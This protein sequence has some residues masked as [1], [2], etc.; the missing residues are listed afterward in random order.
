MMVYG[1]ISGLQAMNIPQGLIF[2]TGAPNPSGGWFVVDLWESRQT[3]DEFTKVLMPFIE[4]SKMDAVQPKI[5]TPHFILQNIYQTQ[6][7]EVLS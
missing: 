3:F 1:T 6:R 4:K 7:E 5:M 2:H